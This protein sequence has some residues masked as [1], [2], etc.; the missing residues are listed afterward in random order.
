MTTIEFWAMEGEKCGYCNMNP[1]GDKQEEIAKTT[2]I[3]NWYMEAYPTDDLGAEITKDATFLGL[4]DTLDTYKDVYDYIGVSDSIVR[5][6]CFEK[7]AEIME[8]DYDYIYE[9]WLRR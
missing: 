2:N 5:E 4:F 9:Q 3:R 8:C 6:R 1:E 7:L